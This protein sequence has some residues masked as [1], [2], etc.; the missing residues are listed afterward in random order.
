MTSDRSQSVPNTV[1]SYWES[2]SPDLPPIVEICVKSWSATGAAAS[3]NFLT[4]E[5]LCDY[6]DPTDLPKR[7]GQMPPVKKA[8]AVRLAVLAR[9][10]G[11]WCDAGVLLTAPIGPWIAQR[12]ATPG[13]FVFRDVD[14]SRVLDTWFISGTPAS[15]FLRE[16]ANHYR[17]FFDRDRMH[18]AH[19]LYKTPSRIATH[20]IVL[21]NKR[22]RKSPARTALWAKPPLS[23]F[24][25]YPYFIMHYIANGLLRDR[26]LR[27]EFD[28]MSKVL[29]SRALAMRTLLDH[30]RLTE[31]RAE[32]IARDV[33]VHK[34]NTYRSYS[35][36]E[37]SILRR[38]SE[39]V[40]PSTDR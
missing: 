36:Q 28:S 10:G 33:P 38:L 15:L 16:W 27:E 22:L 25:M 14:R 12:S 37:L 19:S 18:E 29:A 30:N 34:L 11:H 4:P 6:L 5:T 3:V 8:N 2:D 40:H 31:T 17:R 13:F 21:I 9:H 1:W 32:K 7:F 39:G 23:L 24:P 35:E 26:T 20:I